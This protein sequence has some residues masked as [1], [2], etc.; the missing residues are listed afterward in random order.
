M[1]NRYLVLAA[2]DPTCKKIKLDF[3]R[4]I[5]GEKLPDSDINA[6]Q[7]VLKLQFLNVHG[8]SIK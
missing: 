5:M 2:D 7:R 6:A 1:H 3:E 8:L 4:I